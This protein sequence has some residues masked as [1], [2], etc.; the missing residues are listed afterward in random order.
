MELR[1]TP[2]A[3]GRSPAELVFGFPIRTKLPLHRAQF[4]KE[5]RKQM[6]EADT[7][8]SRL[9][10]KAVSHYNTTARPL[11]HLTR[12][13]IVRVQDP[14]TKEWTRVGE[15][16]DVHHRGRSYTIRTESGRVFWRN[17]KFLR[18]Y[19]KE[20]HARTEEEPAGGSEPRRSTRLRRI[21]FGVEIFVTLNSMTVHEPIQKSECSKNIL[22]LIGVD[23]IP[24]G[25]DIESTPNL[26][27]WDSV[28][29]SFKL[30]NL[31]REKA[32]RDQEEIQH[33]SEMIEKRLAKLRKGPP[34]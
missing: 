12:G 18:R 19:Y 16:I 4:A 26:K 15:V 9:K 11:P 31:E 22:K 8:A 5:W 2:R 13:E 10:E 1:N 21:I 33:Q 3:D 23:L 28:L 34:T 25:E 7:R 24:V 6:A 32:K 27:D 14:V 20:Q 29:L 30:C 17:R